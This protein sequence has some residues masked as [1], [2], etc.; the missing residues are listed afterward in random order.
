MLCS[1]VLTVAKVHRTLAAG[2]RPI[3]AKQ[4]G[5]GETPAWDAN[6]CTCKHFVDRKLQSGSLR[7]PGVHALSGITT[8][9]RA[10]AVLDVS[11]S[12]VLEERDR[13]KGKRMSSLNENQS[14][15][16]NIQL[17]MLRPLRMYVCMYVCMY[18]CMHACMYVC[19]RYIE[20]HI[21]MCV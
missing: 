3:I 20:R 11:H 1:V 12:A 15:R 13:E 10:I 16:I 14:T 17:R 21:C 18:A 2:H 4:Q 5:I 7:K 6:T 9:A 19:L 8:I